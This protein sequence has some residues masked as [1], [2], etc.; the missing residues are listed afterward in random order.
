[1]CEIWNSRSNEIVFGRATFWTWNSV[2]S[3]LAFSSTFYFI[4]FNILSLIVIIEFTKQS[5]LIIISKTKTTQRLRIEFF[6]SYGNRSLLPT[7]STGIDN[8][9]ITR[10]RKIL[11]QQRTENWT[12][13]NSK[14]IG[15]FHIEFAGCRFSHEKSFSLLLTLFAQK[16]ENRTQ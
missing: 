12:K 14:R 11:M 4:I 1:M 7:S 6:H 13:K 5:T 8:E 15:S 2:F 10:K 16:I 9:K 3:H